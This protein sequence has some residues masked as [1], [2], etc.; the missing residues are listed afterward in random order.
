MPNIIVF[1]DSIT[2][3]FYDSEGGWV[4]RL[5][6][7]VSKDAKDEGESNN[8]IYNLG[9]TGANTQFM[10]DRADHE[11][12]PR[13]WESDKTVVIYAMGPNDPSISKSG[14][15]SVP[16]SEKQ[17]RKNLSKLV[18]I[19]RNYKAEIVFVGPAPINEKLVSPAPFDP[20]LSYLDKPLN[21][22][23]IIIKKLCN[24]NNLLF[25]NLLKEFKNTNFNGYLHD[26]LHPNT[27]GHELIYK[28]VKEH[29]IKNKIIK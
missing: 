8:R 10:L 4:D 22:Y 17:F 15:S 29:L 5:K 18:A 13:S 9:V 14:N 7:Y 21:E 25:I 28:T 23:N 12:T 20:D 2:F 26:G 19:A 27:N 6:R 16:V 24:K 3:G 11:I 1:G